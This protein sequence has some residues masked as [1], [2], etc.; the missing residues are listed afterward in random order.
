MWNFTTAR[1]R[2]YLLLRYHSDKIILQ[3]IYAPFFPLF[4]FFSPPQSIVYTSTFQRM[5][6][7][8]LQKYYTVEYRL[9]VSH[10]W[11]F[12]RFFS[13]IHRFIFT[14]KYLTYPSYNFFY[15]SVFFRHIN[16]NYRQ[17]V[18]VVYDIKVKQ[19]F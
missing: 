8:M 18:H 16:Q 11:S 1:A 4:F 15:T 5:Y 13:F 7:G 12:M 9:Y 14:R 6:G 2:C 10:L 19:E 17:F 3:S